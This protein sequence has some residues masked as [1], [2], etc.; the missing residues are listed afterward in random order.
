MWSAIVS[1]G[2]PSAET[3]CRLESSP[4]ANTIRLSGPQL[5]PDE[6][7]AASA[8]STDAPPAA[9][10]RFSRPSAKNPIHFPSHEK[11]GLLA[12]SVPASGAASECSSDRSYKRCPST[13]LAAMT[14]I[15]PSGET[16]TD[17]V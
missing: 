7:A 16:A 6:N 1:T 9:G 8:M 17:D 14:T 2:P 11:N 4:Y 13:S 10:I 3:T 12:R 15:R 5:A